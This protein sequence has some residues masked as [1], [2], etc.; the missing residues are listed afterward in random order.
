LPSIFD[1]IQRRI[2]AKVLLLVC[3]SVFTILF[4]SFYVFEKL[5]YQEKKDALLKQQ[6]LITQSQAIIVPQYIID[7]NEEAITL[8]LSGV[9]SNPI[10]V[11]IAIYDPDGNILHRF[12]D[13]QSKSYQLFEA[14][15]DV[16]MF[17]GASVRRLIADRLHRTAYCGE[18]PT[19]A[20][21]LRP[22]ICRTLLRHCRCGICLHPFNRRDPLEPIGLGD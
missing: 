12:G 2:F 10:I 8:A 14:R 9:L 1:K 22:C 6:K 15:H 7:N 16:T 3:A 11:G 13:F 18:P 5:E 20:A 17:D 19:A 4:S 21:I